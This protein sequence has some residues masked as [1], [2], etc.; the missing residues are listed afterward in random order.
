MPQI[1]TLIACSSAQSAALELSLAQLPQKSL[2][3]Q[4]LQATAQRPVPVYRVQPGA[5]LV[6]KTKG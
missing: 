2:P 5:E 6:L 1:T 4:G 3:A